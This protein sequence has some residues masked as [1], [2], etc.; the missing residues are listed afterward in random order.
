MSFTELGLFEAPA[1][2]PPALSVRDV[3]AS[4]PISRARADPAELGVGGRLYG[5][6][7][8]TSRSPGRVPAGGWRLVQSTALGGDLR[9]VA[10]LAHDDRVLV[11]TAE[12]GLLYTRSGERLA[13][14]IR[15]V[16]DPILV[17]ARGLLVAQTARG[18]LQARSL[19]DGTESFL[20]SAA[21]GATHVRPFIAWRGPRVVITGIKQRA[22]VED[23][24]ARGPAPQVALEQHELP[25]SI[26]NTD[27]FF[28][29][30]L[31]SRILM[32]EGRTLHAALQG[33][34]VIVATDDRLYTFDRQL[35][36]TRLV[37]GEFES[38]ALSVGEGSRAY[39]VV[40][41]P[42]GNE[43]WSI[44]LRGE[45]HFRVALPPPRPGGYAPPIVGY[46]HHVMVPASR[47]IA[48]VAPD[49]R[50][51]ADYPV[52]DA[53]AGAVT[54][55][56]DRLLVTDGAKLLAF[57]RDGRSRVVVDVGDRR[58]RGAPV[59]LPD[60]TLWLLTD[61]ELLRLEPVR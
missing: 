43:L 30:A 11:L 51:V 47:G 18:D 4:P 36:P 57:E 5:D 50:H 17:P 56:D 59:L 39:L 40:G 35:K 38:Q 20:L 8:N 23:P 37:Q 19:R 26:P 14:F 55:A 45:R 32:R 15:G 25:A 3:P 60:G 31:A 34:D 52:S 16:G 33:D 28:R 10:L 7:A 54:T 2:E 41:S 13:T 48:V 42:R 29:G 44:S 6:D 49:G 22:P 46:D 61:Q 1:P 21:F 9:P 24:S 12:R 58:L 53:F 27:G